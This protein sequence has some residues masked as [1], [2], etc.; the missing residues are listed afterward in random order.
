M[1][2]LLPLVLIL[3]GALSVL[4]YAPFDL[5]P[6][7]LPALGVLAWCWRD[8]TPGRAALYGLCWGT[9]AFFAGM[10]WLMVALY[11]Y[12]GMPLPLAVLAIALLS[13]FMGLLPAL[14]G[15]VFARLRRDRW[16]FDALLMAAAWALVEWTRGWLFTGFPWLA[17]GYS[18]TPPSPLAG[19]APIVGVYGVGFIL[20]AVS[21]A[22]VLGW[23]SGARGAASSAA[24]LILVLG[25]GLGRIDWSEPVGAPVRVALV[26]TNVPQ[27][28]KWDR[29]RFQAVL[30][31]NL[32]S[33]RSAHG[34]IVAMP[35]TTVPILLEHVPQ[36]YLAALAA[37]FH[38]EGGEGV[39]GVF[40]RD[41]E[42]HIYNSAVTLGGATQ[43]VY[44]KRHLVPFGEYS[45]PMF[46]WFYELAKIP[47]SDQSRGRSGKP[48]DIAGQ[49]VAVNICYE[50]VFGEELIAALPEATLL[51]NMSNLAWYGNSHAQPQHLQISRMRALETARPM[52]RATNTGMTAVISPKGRVEAVL[53]Q[54]ERGVL[55]ADVRGYQGLTPY[56]RSGN[57]SVVLGAFAVLAFA[58]LRR[59]PA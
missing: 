47:M 46:G 9:G 5:V 21:S 24:A 31:S 55:H 13:A 23:R 48:L 35:E 15:F 49:K 2:R 30:E 25:F 28:M 39:L 27:D 1:N 50:D 6:L 20:M 59:R 37:A 3:S 57:L 26:Q 22:L 42:G 14:A 54:F 41:G 10:G 43:Q 40:T 58:A 52:L 53:P 4:A 17:I 32:E 19:Y 34:Q 11:L 45:P 36:D 29:D 38:A 7:I 12:G 16:A 44:S 33:A 8:A 56:A 51:L 18:Q